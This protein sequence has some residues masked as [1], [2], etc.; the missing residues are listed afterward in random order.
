MKT[1]MIVDDSATMRRMIHASL[2]S[3]D[4]VRFDEAD[5][6]LSAIERLAVAPIDLMTLD[7]N[8]PDMHGLDVLR[9]IRAQPTY[10]SL[11]VLVLTTRGDDEARAASLGAGASICMAKP[12]DPRELA[13]QVRQLLNTV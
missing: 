7:L 3:L 4:D 9:F 8:M 10:Q 11:P 6:G 2:R 13:N 5:S 12:F 1:I